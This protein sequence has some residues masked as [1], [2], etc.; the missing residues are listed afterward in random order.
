M[1]SRGKNVQNSQPSGVG[2]SLWAKISGGR[3]RPG[4]YFSVSTKLD[5]FCYP[6]VQTVPW[7]VPSYWHN[8]GVWWTDGQTDGIAVAGAAL[9]MRSLLHAVKIKFQQLPVWKMNLGFGYNTTVVAACIL[10]NGEWPLHVKCMLRFA[11][12]YF[13]SPWN[14]PCICLF[15]FFIFHWQCEFLRED[16]RTAPG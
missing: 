14:M 13:L 11:W 16:K 10:L 7:Y 9:A 6:T 2:R 15:I 4:E 8:T 12:S 1:A 5:T 3:G